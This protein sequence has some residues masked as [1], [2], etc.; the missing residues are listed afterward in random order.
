MYIS[1]VH[2]RLKKAVMT[3]AA[4]VLLSFAFIEILIIGSA[5]K[6]DHFKADYLIILGASTKNG[7][8][9]ANAKSRLE[10]AMAYIHENPDTAIIVTGGKAPGESASEAAVMAGFLMK[11]GVSRGRLILEELST[12]TYENFKYSRTILR[13]F[14]QRE[15]IS[16]MIITN[17]FHQYRARLIAGHLGFAPYG[18]AADTPLYLVPGCHLREYLAVLKT[19]V[20]DLLLGWELG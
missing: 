8:L 5:I 20:F 19:W 16:L 17:G 12:S 14:D 1:K 15:S 6:E 9:S 7:E 18:Q 2:N 3:A 13:Q 10:K 11:R 4:L